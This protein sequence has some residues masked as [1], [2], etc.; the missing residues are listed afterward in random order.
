MFFIVKLIYRGLTAQSI[1]FA[2][3]LIAPMI[4][5]STNKATSATMIRGNSDEM[6]MLPL[7]RGIRPNNVG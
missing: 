5:L 3:L 6:L 4:I 7:S 1:N 2:E